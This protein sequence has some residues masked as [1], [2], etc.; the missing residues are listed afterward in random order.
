LAWSI[1]SCHN[2][3]YFI[4]EIHDAAQKDDLRMVKALLKD[5]PDLASSKDI[6]E[7][8]PLHLAAQYDHK[9]IADL[10]RKHGG[11]E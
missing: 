6:V 2:N 9:D 7:E 3:S 4:E 11:H 10:L 1:L 8:T 5:N